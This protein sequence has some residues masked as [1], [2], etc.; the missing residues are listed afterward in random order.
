ML[1]AR[2]IDFIASHEGLATRAYRCPAGVLTI[3]Y[4]HTSA[5]G[6]PKVTAG[7]TI[8]TAE[9]RAILARDLGKFEDRVRQV[10][11]AGEPG[12]AIAGGT[13]FDFNT[14]AIRKA[15]WPKSFL[16]GE[17]AAAERQLKQWNK[18]AGKILKGLVRR[19]GEEA[20]IIFRGRWP[21]GYYG[22]T[23]PSLSQT[24]DEL[25]SAAAAIDR[26]G[27]PTVES[28]QKATGL[29]VDGRVGPATRATLERELA[30]RTDRKAAGTGGAG[31]G[32]VVAGHE[33]L[34]APDPAFDWTLLLH[35]L[36]AAAAVGI[37]VL[38]VLW[39]WRNRGRFT[40][41][42]IPT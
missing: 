5:A 40:G 30:K 33:G 35:G 1:D 42:R 24:N 37:A 34:A 25:A 4:G 27:Y 10:F 2:A 7:M 17:L 16:A 9:A 14:G 19:R 26:L 18:G 12:Q 22:D 8:T 20:D 29:V 41:T 3:G 28:F 15:S 23:D 21:D 13:S 39:L 36:L 11:P 31:A 38:A 32:S 6:A